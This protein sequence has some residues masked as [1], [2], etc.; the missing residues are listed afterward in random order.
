MG[1]VPPVRR[2]PDRKDVSAFRPGV[3]V[4]H[5]RFGEGVIVSIAGE[6]GG[7]TYAEIEFASTGKMMLALDYAPLELADTEES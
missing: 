3:R 4:R 6:T 2:E 7:N 5:R 1:Y